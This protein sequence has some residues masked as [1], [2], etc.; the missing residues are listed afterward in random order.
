MSRLGVVNCSS[1][2]R[3]NGR[4]SGKKIALR[5]SNVNWLASASI[6]EK[7]GFTV[8]FSVR[9]EVTPQRTVPPSDGS[10]RVVGPPAR[11]PGAPSIV[12]VSSGCQVQHQP[13]LQLREAVERARPGPGRRRPRACAGAQE[14]SCAFHCC[15]RVTWRP[16]DWRVR[17]GEAQGLEGNRAPRPRSR[18]RVSRP[19]ESNTKS[20]DRSGSS[21]PVASPSKPPP[22]VAGALDQHAVRLHAQRVHREVE[23]LAAVVERGQEDADLVLGVEA[24]AVGE[25]RPHR[26]RRRVR[27]HAEVDRGGGVEDE[28]LGRLVAGARRPPARR[29]RSPSDARPAA[30]A[31]RRARRRCAPRP[32][33]RGIATCSRPSRPL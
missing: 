2:S 28:H 9:F 4:F 10:L 18:P 21:R 17:R 13:A 8:P 33:R 29:S 14:S 6:C 23:R 3:K 1:P 20:G 15:M 30:R 22:R 5:G 25:R 16:H 26:A 24:V 32:S 11:R 27:A 12:P 19:F 31:R 7:S